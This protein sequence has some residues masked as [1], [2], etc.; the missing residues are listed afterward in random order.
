MRGYDRRPTRDDTDVI[1]K[2]IG[3]AIIDSIVMGV[4]IFGFVFIGAGAV[5]GAGDVGAAA[6]FASL[7][8]IFG[9]LLG[10]GYFFLLEG[11]WDGQTI[12]K[13]VLGIKVVKEDGSECDIG[14]SVIR[15]LLRI[16]DGLFYYAVGFIFMAMSDQRQRLGDRVGGTVVVKEAP[17]P[18][19]QPQYDESW[20]EGRSAQSRRR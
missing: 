20:D 1:G 9:L 18:A 13:K 8:Y 6:G 19:A 10:L 7:A 16:I 5:F 11:F 17:D 12:G 15:N 3:A 2:R 14:A 4:I